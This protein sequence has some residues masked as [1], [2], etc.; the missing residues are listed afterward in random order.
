MEYTK[1]SWKD[2][3]ANMR[4][5]WKDETQ[6]KNVRTGAA[7]RLSGL[8]SECTI[9]AGL[10]NEWH[11]V[12]KSE[13]SDIRVKCT[14]QAGHIYGQS[15]EVKCNDM[16]LYPSNDRSAW[17]CYCVLDLENADEHTA[18]FDAVLLPKRLFAEI[19]KECGMATA[20]AIS[21]PDA[22]FRVMGTQELFHSTTPTGRANK[23]CARVAKWLDA[24]REAGM[25]LDDFMDKYNV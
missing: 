5:L 25:T 16:T 9:R 13:F 20:P 10:T 22:I 17:I 21:Q 8:L 3:V 12:A 4:K 7:R 24:L 23:R 1:Q 15:I 19:T 11:S 14:S 6:D 2:E 18:P